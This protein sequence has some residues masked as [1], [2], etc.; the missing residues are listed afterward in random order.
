MDDE[1]LDAFAAERELALSVDDNVVSA[2]VWHYIVELWSEDGYRMG[3]L[4]GPS[5]DDGLRGEPGPWS[6][7]NPPWHG[8]RDIWVDQNNRLWVLLIYRRPDWEERV[9][10]VIQRNGDVALGFPQGVSSVYRSRIEIVDLFDCRT[11]AS[12]WFEEG[13]LG[14]FVRGTTAG[15]TVA[16]TKSSVGPGGVPLVDVWNVGV[17]R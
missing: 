17:V 13:A 10:E 3:K 2:R 4:S 5:L 16:V 8:V 12:G 9:M 7:S 1:P 14:R 6:I 11:I 15:D